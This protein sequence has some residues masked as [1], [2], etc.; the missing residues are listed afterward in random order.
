MG[1]RELDGLTHRLPA[2]QRHQGR[3]HL[4]GRRHR[5]ETRRVPDFARLDRSGWRKF[6]LRARSR[7]E[8]GEAMKQRARGLTLIELMVSLA[9]GSLLIIGAV[10]VYS[11]SRTTYRVSDT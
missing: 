4:Q 8:S 1:P 3:C 2:Q 6:F 7:S 10:T 9:I 5:G 11:Q